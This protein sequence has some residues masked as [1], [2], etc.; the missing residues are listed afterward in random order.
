MGMVQGIAEGIE[1]LVV[2]ELVPN[3]PRRAHCRLRCHL[4]SEVRD[5]QGAAGA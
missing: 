5:I 3:D 1:G 2:D 4:D